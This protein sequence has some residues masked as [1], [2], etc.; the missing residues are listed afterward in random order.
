MATYRI[1]P[2][3]G[4]ARLGNSD[5]EFYIAPE[6]PAALPLACDAQGNPRY[7]PDGTTPVLV[8]TFKDARGPHQAAGRALPDLRLRR[9]LTRR[10]GRSRSATGSKAAAIAAR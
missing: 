9:G 2:G 6:T 8:T 1:H 3:I 7:G 4:I 5:T 10:A